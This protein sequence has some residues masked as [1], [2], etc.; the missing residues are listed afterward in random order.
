MS[1][2]PPSEGLEILEIDAKEKGGVGALDG[3]TL[4]FRLE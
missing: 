4:E 3:V 1:V 2:T